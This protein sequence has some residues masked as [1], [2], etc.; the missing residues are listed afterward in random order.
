[1]VIIL[2]LRFLPQPM[3]QQLNCPGSANYRRLRQACEEHRPS[4][5][6]ASYCAGFL[7]IENEFQHRGVVPVVG[8]DAIEALSSLAGGE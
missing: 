7:A 1:M 8:I 5:S 2:R 6:K 4:L 3:L